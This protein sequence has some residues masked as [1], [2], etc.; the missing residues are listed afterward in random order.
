MYFKFSVMHSQKQELF[1]PLS[2][3]F[4]SI[5]QNEVD[6]PFPNPSL[7]LDFSHIT[8]AFIIV[9]FLV[10]FFSQMIESGQCHSI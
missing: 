10:K 4:F 9:P 8:M 7:P 5:K 2:L 3:S 6:F 1:L